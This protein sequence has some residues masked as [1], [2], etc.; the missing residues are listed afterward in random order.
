[1]TQV[2]H[3][4]QG[5]WIDDAALGARLEGLGATLDA[6]PERFPLDALLTAADRLAAALGR[7]EP[8]Y[9]ELE[10]LVRELGL[11]PNTIFG[12]HRGIDNLN[13]VPAA[14]TLDEIKS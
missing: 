4:W 3:L 8:P 10:S 9:A 11:T 1:M 12:E 13:R 5:E 14:H 2:Q 7:R 6:L